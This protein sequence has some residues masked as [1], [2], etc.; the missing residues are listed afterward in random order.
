MRR[1]ALAALLAATL[2]ASTGCRTWALFQDAPTKRVA[3]EYPYLTDKRV[4]ILVRADDETEFT[5]QHVRWEVADHVKVA[6]EANIEGVSVVDPRRVV[7]FQNKQYDWEYLDQ[8]EIGERFGA[9]RLIEI[10]L[11]QYTTREPDSPHLYRGHITASVR[12]YN[13]DYAESEP[14]YRAEVQTVYPPDG[15]APWGTSDR[16][17]RA[18]MMQAF[19]DE[20]AGKFYDRKVKVE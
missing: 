16:E 5:Y 18:G 17:V 6:L 9:D 2:L 15:P 3:A 13:T 11:T 19:A 4:C 12:V 8:A 1:L 10:D 20:L 14:V 7:D